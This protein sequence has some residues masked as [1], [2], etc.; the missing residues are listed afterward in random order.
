MS[1]SLFLRL[2]G[3]GAVV[4][5]LLASFTP[6]PNTLNRWAGVPAQVKPAAAI[7]VLGAGLAGNGVLSD[8][9]LRRALY[10]IK[11]YHEGFAPLLVFSGPSNGSSL[12]EAQVRADMAR[13]FGVPP[14]AIMTEATAQTTRQEAARMLALLQPMGIQHILLVTS[15]E[16]MA[17]SQRLFQNVGF[18]VQPAPVDDLS[19]ADRP[20]PRLRLMRQVAQEFLARAYYRFAGYL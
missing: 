10:G 11:L 13:L 14:T 4:F 20:E 7:V 15:Y 17:R 19:Y 2:L 12:E 9:S 5:F 3:Q 16:H 6:L 18:T 1:G 8:L